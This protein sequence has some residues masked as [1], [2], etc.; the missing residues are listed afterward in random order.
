MTSKN[1]QIRIFIH[2]YINTIHNF[3]GE[4][5][6]QKYLNLSLNLSFVLRIVQTSGEIEGGKIKIEQEK[7]VFENEIN[8]SR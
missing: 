5:K 8:R 6:I 2:I 1:F 4:I 7:D 3:N